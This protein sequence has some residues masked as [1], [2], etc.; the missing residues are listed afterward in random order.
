MKLN[1]YQLIQAVL[2]LNEEDF[3]FFKLGVGHGEAARRAEAV[4]P[5]S[6]AM[7]AVKRGKRVTATDRIKM[8][9]VTYP[10]CNFTSSEAIEL[11]TKDGSTPK[12]IHVFLATLAATPELTRV[13]KGIY[14]F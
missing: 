3:A 14:H 10:T 1:P 2:A 13:E 8:L 12:A 11:L 9:R 7:E 4:L 6:L 5:R